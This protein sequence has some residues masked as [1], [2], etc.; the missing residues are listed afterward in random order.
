MASENLK[1]RAKSARSGNVLRV[2]YALEYFRKYVTPA[3]IAALTELPYATVMNSLR[4][5]LRINP[6][7]E[8]DD[9][10]EDF[11]VRFNEVRHRTYHRNN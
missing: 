11:R 9:R 4:Q 2:L 10:A 5:L 8:C 3:D 7:V 6:F 1:R